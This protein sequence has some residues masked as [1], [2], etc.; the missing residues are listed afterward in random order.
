MKQPTGP[1]DGIIIVT[2]N[3]GDPC[4]VFGRNTV[5]D[6]VFRMIDRLDREAP[7]DAP[8]SAWRYGAGGFS[9]V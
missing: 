9:R 1:V 7:G 2:D 5:Y 8:H 4:E 6:V 3:D